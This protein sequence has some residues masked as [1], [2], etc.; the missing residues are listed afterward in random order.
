MEAEFVE[1]DRSSAGYPFTSCGWVSRSNGRVSIP[2]QEC[3][4]RSGPWSVAADVLSGM[5]S[6]CLSW[7]GSW[8]C[9]VRRSSMHGTRFL[10]WLPNWATL[11]SKCS[12][13]RGMARLI[14]DVRRTKTNE[15]WHR[16][17]HE[18]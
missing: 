11:T 12:R 5:R 8:W 1:G 4:W 2:R 9:R 15:E 7:R 16:A 13:R 17:R 6:L 18:R 3:G 14:R 10:A